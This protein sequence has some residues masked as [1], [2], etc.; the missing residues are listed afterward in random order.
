MSNVYAPCV[1]LPD[2]RNR[3]SAVSKTENI[4]SFLLLN[5]M[6]HSPYGSIIAGSQSQRPTDALRRKHGLYPYRVDRLAGCR[7]DSQRHFKGECRQYGGSCAA[8]PAYQNHTNSRLPFLRF[9]QKTRS[10]VRKKFFIVRLCPFW[11]I[12]KLKTNTI[13]ERPP[14]DCTITS[15]ANI[16]PLGVFYAAIAVLGAKK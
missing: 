1:T 14:A 3:F 6:I 12:N 2:A 4:R 5:I 7:G 16:K 8:A 15:L 13:R 9:A 10:I 11:T